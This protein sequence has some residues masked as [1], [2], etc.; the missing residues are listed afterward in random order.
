[1]VCCREHLPY[2]PG[3]CSRLGGHMGVCM[4][5][6]QGGPVACACWLKNRGGC[7]QFIL[8]CSVQCMRVVLARWL[9]SR[10]HVAAV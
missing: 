1:M 10:L 5:V 6:R 9:V 7:A 3:L 2:S 8:T 4:G